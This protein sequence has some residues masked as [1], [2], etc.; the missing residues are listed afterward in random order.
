MKT[1]NLEQQGNKPRKRGT[2]K[3]INQ[4]Q[5]RKISTR[6]KNT[7]PMPSKSRSGRVLAGKAPAESPFRGPRLTQQFA[8]WSGT[9]SG[10]R[11]APTMRVPNK[12]VSRAKWVVHIC[13]YIYIYIYICMYVCKYVR[14][15]VGRQVCMY[16]TT[17][18][19]WRSTAATTNFKLMGMLTC[20]YEW[21]TNTFNSYALTHRHTKRSSLQGLISFHSG[22]PKRSEKQVETPLCLEPMDIAQF[23]SSK[24]GLF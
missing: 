12:F 19:A 13:V 8:L 1:R 9:P 22:I 2:T 4:G 18:L 7:G 21:E 15:Y 10:F 23:C 3:K 6:G 5:R 17:L 16:G 14:T 11:V 24:S 20:T